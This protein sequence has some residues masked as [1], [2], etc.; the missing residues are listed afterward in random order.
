M[1]HAN[2]TNSYPKNISR[3]DTETT[4]GWFVRSYYGGL[5][6]SMYLSDKKSE[7]SK[8]KSFDRAKTLVQAWQLNT[9]KAVAEEM[10]PYAWREMQLAMKKEFRKSMKR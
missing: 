2:K 3:L 6:V 5:E 10:N 8:D 1:S 9:D 7:G 4:K